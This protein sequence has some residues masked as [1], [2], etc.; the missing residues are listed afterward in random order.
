MGEMTAKGG[1][2]TSVLSA[3]MQRMMANGG[4]H[5]TCEEWQRLE[6]PLVAL[7]PV[8]NQFAAAHKLA[9]SKN[10]KNS[11]ERS[12]HW[13]DNPRFLIQLYLASEAGPSWNLWL[14]CSE[15]RGESRYWR[16]DF[17]IEGQPVQAFQDQLPTILM[18]GLNQLKVWGANPDQFEFATRLAPLPPR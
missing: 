14:C 17:A 18:D 6:A 8:L 2:R 16:Q 15:D 5:G 12:L 13:G 10:A 9:M 1:K 7:D 4:W 11:P 3:V